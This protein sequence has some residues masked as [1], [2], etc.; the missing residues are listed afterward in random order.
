MHEIF[1][2]LRCAG[3]WYGG[4]ASG[5]KALA[6]AAA[7]VGR[8]TEL[9]SADVGCWY[10]VCKAAWVCLPASARP[11]VRTRVHALGF[12]RPYGTARAG[13]IAHDAE[14]CWSARAFV[15]CGRVCGL[16]KPN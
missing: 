7:G 10:V 13:T 11:A 9:V 4:G 6:A 8:G 5:S 2:E 14:S 3:M 15:V 1:W 16:D 12:A